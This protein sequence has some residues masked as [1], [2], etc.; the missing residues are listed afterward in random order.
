MND[1]TLLHQQR[2]ALGYITRETFPD[3]TALMNAHHKKTHKISLSSKSSTKAHGTAKRNIGTIE[4]SGAQIEGDGACVRIR[5]GRNPLKT[6]RDL[7]S[8]L[9]SKPFGAK[10]S[11][12]FLSSSSDMNDVELPSIL[13]DKGSC[14]VTLHF[15]VFFDS[16][17]LSSNSQRL[18][19]PRLLVGKRPL[20]QHLSVLMILLKARSLINSRASS[21]VPGRTIQSFTEWI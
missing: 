11:P 5:R 10:V 1:L 3:G 8:S 4:C 17:K 12:C 20:S 21:S 16:W 13:A 2:R 18:L 15:F 14:L 7:F 9:N 19:F 6:R